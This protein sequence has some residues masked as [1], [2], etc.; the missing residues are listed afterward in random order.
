M[1]QALVL[2]PGEA[3]VSSHL[4]EHTLQWL[5]TGNNSQANV[6]SNPTILRAHFLSSMEKEAKRENEEQQEWGGELIQRRQD[7]PF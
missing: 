3:T 4:R 2:G 6:F 7:R 5:T 1:C